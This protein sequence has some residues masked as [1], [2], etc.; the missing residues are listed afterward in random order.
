MLSA[1]VVDA[2]AVFLLQL[3][4]PM[5]RAICVSVAGLWAL[6]SIADADPLPNGATLNWTRL[7]IS[8]PG[9]DAKV[10]P[11]DP[12]ALRFYL[13]LAHCECARQMP[14]LPTST[15]G[16][17]LQLSNTTNMG[18]AA[19]FL[20]GTE[21]DDDVKRPLQCR[22]IPPRIGDIDA[23][24]TETEYDVNVYDLIQGFD[25]STMACNQI[26]GGQ[27]NLWFVV[28][29]NKDTKPDYFAQQP[30][31]LNEFPGDVDGFDTQPPPLPINVN[32]TGG[33]K[34]VTITWDTPTERPGDLY[35]FR[36]L[37]MDAA[38]QAPVGGDQPTANFETVTDVCG[39]PNN[40]VLTQT[41]PS[42]GTPEDMPVNEPAA[43][44]A[45]DQAFL[46]G[47]QVDTGTAT[48]LEIS[49]LENGK[50]YII[51][52]LA[53]DRSGNVTGTYFNRTITP[54]PVTDFWEDLHGR[55]SGVEGGLCLLAE[56]Y[57]DQGPITRALRAFR[58]DTL[59]RT[60]FGR[61][62]TRAY[63]ATLGKLGGLV[64]GSLALR[65]VAAIVLAPLVVLALLWHALSLPVLLALLA[66]VIWRR[67]LVRH[68]PRFA[69]A[70]VMLVPLLARADEWS[71]YWEEE[72]SS[73]SALADEDHVKWH[74]GVRIGPYTPDI[75]AQAG[76]N[77]SSMMGPYQAM[78]G[79]YYVNGKAF[80]AHV[81]QW[82][83]TLDVDR[84]LWRGF[85]QL[86]IGGS[87]GYMQKS[88]YAYQEG[89]AECSADNPQRPRS[90]AGRNTFR[91]IPM[92]VEATYRLTTL[93]DDY[94]IPLVPYLR[95]GIAYDVWWLKGP[96]GNISS[97]CKDGSMTEDCDAN[98]ALGAS[99]GLTGS[100]GLA[101]RAE[102]VDPNAARSMKQSGIYHAG[103]Y[104]ELRF[105]R[106][107]GFGSDKKLSVGDKTWF[108]GVDFEF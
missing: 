57:G 102:R 24:I 99:L 32:A 1:I 73:E 46:C 90:K 87:L 4:V 18:L 12:D 52:L 19:D 53:V 106:V 9:D 93:D 94:G 98:K 104:G 105:A 6:G 15:I 25:T 83:P 45:L 71:P 54:Q 10:E 31:V 14:A 85:G 26:D 74:A 84:V 67:R 80:D 5:I 42:V 7:K 61:A 72:N 108:A 30:I 29:T 17:L 48:S 22:T 13:N 21:C 23:L 58:D 81:Y 66:L 37:C 28:D 16:Y 59:A 35:R 100:L 34:S 68:V 60:G 47:E 64:H 8:E 79:N 62:L 95:G 41:E 50:Q 20:V 78:F 43:F 49:G 69:F 39:L 75:D 65:V 91:F 76:V 101:I 86:A 27:S 33:E 56:T 96:D 38:G 88:A 11:T 107:D 36:A 2:T 92:S 55:G 44:A 3:A 51:A 97:I 70:A 89:C 103:F 40:V 77:P 63:Y 82:L